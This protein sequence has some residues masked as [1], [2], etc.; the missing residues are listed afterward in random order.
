MNITGTK[1]AKVADRNAIA[2]YFG[3]KYLVVLKKGQTVQK[4]KK[5]KGE[6]RRSMYIRPYA[7]TVVCPSIPQASSFLPLLCRDFRKL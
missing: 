5:R 3:S 4:S 6:E 2:L 7:I 1:Q